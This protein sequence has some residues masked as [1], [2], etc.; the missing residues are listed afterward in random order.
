[1][2]GCFVAA[3]A[4]DLTLIKRAYSTNVCRLSVYFIIGLSHPRQKGYILLKFKKCNSVFAASGLIA[5][6]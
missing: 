2:H 1:M 6:G 4:I 3:K 5:I